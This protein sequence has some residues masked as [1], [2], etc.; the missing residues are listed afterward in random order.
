MERKLM[1]TKNNQMIGG[2]CT[3]LAEYFNTDVTLVRA[4]FLLAFFGAGFGF[5]IYL[6]LWVILPENLNN[7]N[8]ANTMNNEN[9]N[10]FDAKFDENLSPG[11]DG[12]RPYENQP[13]KRQNSAVGGYI[14]LGLGVL[15]LINNFTDIHFDK[16]WPIILI[17]VG[18][19]ILLKQRDTQSK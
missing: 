4:G 18:A 1:R 16:L 5:L 2:V 14:L 9:P 19:Y 15:F 3:G 10:Q 8:T 13:S 12:F 7:F 6:I 17:V 11:T